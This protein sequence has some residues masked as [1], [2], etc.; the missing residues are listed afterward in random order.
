MACGT[1]AP[2]N[3]KRS[4]RVL[5][6]AVNELGPSALVGK[7]VEKPVEVLRR[8]RP[9]LGRKPR[10]LVEDESAAVLVDHHVADVLL[11]VRAQGIV[12]RLPWRRTSGRCLERRYPYL[13]PGLD[14]VAGNGPFPGK[15]QLA[16]PRPA[17]D[18]VEAYFRHV[19]LEPAVETDPVIL[20]GHGKGNGFAHERAISES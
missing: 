11:L 16:R 3:E 2:C 10:R 15:A 8:L 4:R 7:S 5:V 6:E 18:E 9:A 12:P 17:R 19:P 20:V 1:R 14:P 13:L